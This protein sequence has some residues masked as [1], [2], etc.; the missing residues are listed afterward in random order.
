MALGSGFMAL[1]FGFIALNFGF[2][3]H[4]YEFK[5]L[6]Y[7]FMTRSEDGTTTFDNDEVPIRNGS[8]G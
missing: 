8:A 6:G 4:S 5:A 2:M 3:A 7:M 1:D